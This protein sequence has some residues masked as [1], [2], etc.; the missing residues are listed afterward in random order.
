VWGKVQ[1]AYPKL[2]PEGKKGVT[3]AKEKEG[4][5]G[6]KFGEKPKKREKRKDILG[7]KKRWGCVLAGGWEHKERGNHRGTGGKKKTP[8]N[9]EN[10]KGKEEKKSKKVLGQCHGP[11][12]QTGP[13]CSRSPSK[14]P[15]LKE[16]D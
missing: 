11:R 9:L 10:L 3:I 12:G 14:E 13:T 16:E 7:K 5:S 2:R 15:L 8:T 6:K 1:C 4:S